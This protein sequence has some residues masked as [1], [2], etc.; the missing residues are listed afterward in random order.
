MKEVSK[1][2]FYQKKKIKRLFFNFKKDK[3]YSLSGKT[4]SLPIVSPQVDKLFSDL[5]KIQ[6]DKRTFPNPLNF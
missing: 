6:V 2:Q 3:K 1:Q 5:I 4:K